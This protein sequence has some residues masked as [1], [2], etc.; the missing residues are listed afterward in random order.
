M[1]AK[2]VWMSAFVRGVCKPSWACLCAGW[3]AEWVGRLWAF[4][5]DLWLLV[6][7]VPY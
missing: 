3:K 1:L 4:A 2:L 5:I 6:S 7:D